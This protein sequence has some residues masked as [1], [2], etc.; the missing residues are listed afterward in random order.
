MADGKL[1]FPR[2]LLNLSCLVLAAALLAGCGGK[3]TSWR[4]G[5]V[6]GSRPYT[7]RGKTYYPLKSAHGFVEEGVASW[8]GPGFHGKRTAS[9]ERFNQYNISA[10]HKIL[11][12]GTE[13]RVTNLE[14][15]RSLILRINDRGPFV[16][17]RVI[18]LSRGAA[19]RLT[20][21]GHKGR[22]IY[23]S[24]NLWNVQVGPWEDSRKADEMMRVLRAL[25]PHAFVVGDGGAS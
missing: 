3:D 9:G 7:V 18:D 21:S 15:H 24:N 20:G 14:N 22:M 25:Y 16:D 1:S 17:D 4:K 19:Q 13:V 12:L 2:L 8:Y 10:A 11:P 23:G 6:P 5:G